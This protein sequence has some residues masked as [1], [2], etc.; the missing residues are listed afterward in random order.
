MTR[1]GPTLDAPVLNLE[2]TPSCDVTCGLLPSIILKPEGFW[3]AKLD[4]RDTLPGTR[5]VATIWQVR[6]H[7]A[8]E[9]TGHRW[10]HVQ[11]CW[12]MSLEGRSRRAESMNAFSCQPT[13]LELAGAVLPA[14]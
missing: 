5:F 3:G 4:L 2:A 7:E 10:A 13:G 6:T 8:C 1:G 14:K 9:K 12:E 11:L